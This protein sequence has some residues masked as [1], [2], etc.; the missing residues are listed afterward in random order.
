MTTLKIEGLHIKFRFL[1]QLLLK[2]IRSLSLL[3]SPFYGD[4]SG[5]GWGGTISCR[6]A[7]GLPL[8]KVLIW[9]AS[10]LGSPFLVPVLSLCS[11]PLPSVTLSL[12]CLYS[13][14]S[15]ICVHAIPVHLGYNCLRAAWLS[16]HLWLIRTEWHIVNTQSFRILNFWIEY[17]RF[18]AELICTVMTNWVN[19][20]LDALRNVLRKWKE[21]WNWGNELQITG[22]EGRANHFLIWNISPLGFCFLSL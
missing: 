2:K 8:N 22:N 13:F 15:I 10:D 21:V 6:W 17:L 20:V 9:S 19:Q 14:C 12:P 5:C 7:S 1:S 11:D 3:G 16:F 18:R 4:M